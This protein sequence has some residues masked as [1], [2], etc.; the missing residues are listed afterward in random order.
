MFPHRAFVG[1]FSLFILVSVA[2]EIGWY[3]LVLRR[4]YPWPEMRTS[5]AIF[6]M[7]M[8]VKLIVPVITA[9][10]VYFLWTHRIA[11][12]PLHTAWGL[13]LLF[14]AEEFAYYWMHRAGHE[15]RWLWASHVVHHTPE[16]IHLASAFRIGVTEFLSGN[17]LFF[18]PLFVLGFNPAAVGAMLAVNLF[19]QFW[20]HTDLVGRLGPLEWVLNTPSHHRVHHASNAAYLDR[21]YGGILI[22]WD[23]IFGTY[24]EERPGTRIVYGLVHPIGTLNPIRITFHEWFAMARDASRARTWR[25]RLACLFGRP[26]AVAGRPVPAE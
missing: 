21:N 13:A 12:V 20:L 4:A 7:R 11:T 19:Y 10:V 24:A 17:W 23:R 25:Q 5:I 6:I 3:L 16:Q 8:P 2:F 1:W 9:P 14:L 15:V 22:V 18:L 26:G